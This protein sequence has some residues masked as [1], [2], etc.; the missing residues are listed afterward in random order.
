MSL[1]TLYRNLEMGGVFSARTLVV[2]A[3]LLRAL[4]CCKTQDDRSRTWRRMQATI[5]H[6]DCSQQFRALTGQ[7]TN[8]VGA[9]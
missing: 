5:R 3:K 6:G 9:E 2:S 1:R 8:Q 4:A 7:T